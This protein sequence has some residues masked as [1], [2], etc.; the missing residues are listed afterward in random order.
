MDS[1]Y[2]SLGFGFRVSHVGEKVGCCIPLEQS[3]SILLAR[4]MLT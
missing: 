1:Y 2:C 3:T 4:G